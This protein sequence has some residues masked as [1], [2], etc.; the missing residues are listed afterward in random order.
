M[1]MKDGLLLIDKPGGITSHD[2]VASCR[3]LLGRRDIGHAGTLDPI[4][5]GLLIILVG[6]A[7]KLSDFILKGDKVYEATLLLGHETDT[8]DISG[9][10]LHRSRD[11]NLDHEQVSKAVIDLTGSLHLPVP[12]YSAV[13]VAGSKLYQKA[14]RGE[15]FESPIRKMNFSG[16]RLLDFGNDRVSV[17]LSCARGSYIRSWARAL[18]KILGCGATVEA[19]RRLR[20]EPYSLKEATGIAALENPDKGEEESL[21]SAFIPLNQSLPD[22][23]PVKIEGMDEK[24]ISNGQISRGL[25]RFLELEFGDREPG[26]KLLSR[27][28]GRLLS[29]LIYQ[30]PGGFK[31]QRVFPI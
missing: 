31:I 20:S 21:G 22:F 4:A 30:S 24:L 18:G 19:L 5:T 23:P 25:G 15:T 1:N 2:V 10:L 16:V 8:D 14:R 17:E 29:V 28:S 27:H 11:L 12:I 13:K 9:K 3:R 26:V 6:K 7:T